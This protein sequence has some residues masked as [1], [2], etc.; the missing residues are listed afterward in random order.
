MVMNHSVFRLVVSSLL[1]ATAARA[2]GG[3]VHVAD[4]GAV[5]DDGRCDAKAIDAAIHA[6]AI[7][8][9]S[10]VVFAAGTYLL[11]TPIAPETRG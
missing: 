1:A 6:A 2:G 5:P 3:A 11:S 7:S 10:C 9:R 8:N 4:F